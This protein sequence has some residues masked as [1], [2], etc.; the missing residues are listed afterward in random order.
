M[1]SKWSPNTWIV[2]EDTFDEDNVVSMSAQRT[3]TLCRKCLRLVSPQFSTSMRRQ[4]SITM[5]QI[6]IF[7][8][9]WQLKEPEKAKLA[10]LQLSPI[11]RLWVM[12]TFKGQPGALSKYIRKSEQTNAWASPV[13]VAVKRPVSSVDVAPRPHQARP[14][15]PGF[16]TA[17]RP[18]GVRPASATGATP[19]V[20]TPRS[21]T[22]PR[23]GVLAP[24]P[25]QTRP[26]V[27]GFATAAP[28]MGVRPA[29]AIGA[30][31]HK[32]T[33]TMHAS[34]APRRSCSAPPAKRT[35]GASA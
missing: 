6:S 9:K 2:V 30:R 18:M 31:P 10:L 3:L 22:P 35:L 13:S 5:E 17:V 34:F 8:A 32:S 21:A 24:R 23:L 4:H 16:A 28:R 14:L 33:V 25:H 29:S 19:T 15:V 1:I 27:S 20:A 26:L 12:T 11:R 7:I